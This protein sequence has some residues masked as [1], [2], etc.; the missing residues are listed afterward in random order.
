MNSIHDDQTADVK[1]ARGKYSDAVSAEGSVPNSICRVIHFQDHISGSID[2]GE[3]LGRSNLFGDI[4][5]VAGRVNVDAG[6]EIPSIE[7]GAK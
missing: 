4:E 5:D 2:E 7:A 6:V 1:G 3:L